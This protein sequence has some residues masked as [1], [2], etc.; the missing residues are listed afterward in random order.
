MALERHPEAARAMVEL[1]HESR[2][3]AGAGST[4]RAVDEATEREHLKAAIAAIEAATGQRPLGWY[5]GRTSENTKNA[6]SSEEGG[7]LYDAD[8]YADEPALLGRGRRARSIVVVP[9][10]LDANDM[11]FATAQ[12]FNSGDQFFALIICA[13]T[14]DVL[15]AAKGERA[16]KLTVGRAALS[17]SRATRA[18]SRV[19]ALSS[20][21][22]DARHADVWICRRIDHPPAHGTRLHPASDDGDMPA[23]ES[24]C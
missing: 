18:G 23:C 22:V 11:R 24:L 7:F 9:Y 4:N 21:H 16:R 12:G 2:A 1:G 10:T 20:D 19:A 5:T 15:Y 8:S 17:P 3:T 6:S 14:F 13:D